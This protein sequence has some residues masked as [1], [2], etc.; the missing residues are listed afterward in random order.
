MWNSM[1]HSG[2]SMSGLGGLNAGEQGF[3]DH[4]A[5]GEV[6]AAPSQ[7]VGHPAADV[8]ADNV[9]GAEVQT[10]DELGDVYGE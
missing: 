5:A 7:G 9:G 3:Q 6:G 10:V 1:C 8:V 4:H 2:T